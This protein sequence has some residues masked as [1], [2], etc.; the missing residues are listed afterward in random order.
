MFPVQQTR[1]AFHLH[2][3]RNAFRRRDVHKRSRLLVLPP[4]GI[5]NP[6]CDLVLPAIGQHFSNPIN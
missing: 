4:I 6:D 1:S 5:D 2:A 3:Q